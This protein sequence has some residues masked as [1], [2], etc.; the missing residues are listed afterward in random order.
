MTAYFIRRLLLIIPTFLGITLLV[1]II[2]RFVPGGPVE[3]ILAEARQ[4]KMG[5]V[6]HGSANT[7]AQTSPLS[8]SQIEELKKFYGFDKPVLVSYWEW[9]KK[10]MV[11]DLG[12]STRYYDPVWD[13]I[14]D[15]LPVS[16]YYGFATTVLTYLIC[17]PLGIFK[18]IR[19]KT[20][21]DSATSVVVLVGYALPGFIVAIVLFVWPA[22]QWD[23]F[24]LGG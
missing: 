5:H 22:A 24:P 8:P 14:R 10:I 3:K 13:I 7:P 17:I 21:M 20:M 9:L 12:Y 4:M 23:W 6:S 16:I 11:L 15:K 19:H 18:A 1:F 2:T